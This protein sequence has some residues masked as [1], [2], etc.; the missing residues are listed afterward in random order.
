MEKT[1][2][3]YH[4]T[5][6]PVQKTPRKCREKTITGEV[7]AREN[8]RFH[9]LTLKLIHK[10]IMNSN[11]N[12]YLAPDLQVLEVDEKPGNVYR[13]ASVNSLTPH[14]KQLKG[15]RFMGLF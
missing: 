3:I 14:R 10:I 5:E 13:E 6:N 1:K 2:I 11:G 9:T 4:N 7:P 8:R 12:S 15:R